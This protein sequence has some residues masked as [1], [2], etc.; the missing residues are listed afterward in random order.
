MTPSETGPLALDLDQGQIIITPSEPGPLLDLN[1]GQ[2]VM[3]LSETGPL[4][5]DLD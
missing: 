2:T 1:H 5:L 4:V 3:P